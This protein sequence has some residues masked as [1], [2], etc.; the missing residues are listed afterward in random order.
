MSKNKCNDDIHDHLCDCNEPDSPSL[1]V[2]KIVMLK[3]WIAEAL[4]DFTTKPTGTIEGDLCDWNKPSVFAAN[5]SPA[6]LQKKV[7]ERV[8]YTLDYLIEQQKA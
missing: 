4:T 3:G 5:Y 6:E 2:D 1:P 8:L 7:V